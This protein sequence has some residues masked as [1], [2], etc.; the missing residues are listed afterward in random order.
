MKDLVRH[1]ADWRR[2]CP[3][4]DD[5]KKQCDSIKKKL[6]LLHEYQQGNI[7]PVVKE[8]QKIVMQ[9]SQSSSEE[10]EEVKE[11]R[12]RKIR[13]KNYLTSNANPAVNTDVGSLIFREKPPLKKNN[14]QERLPQRLLKIHK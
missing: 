12:K 1:A 3:V 6:I 14:S 8:A 4:P 10:E 5:V 7:R 13:I 11:K 2:P 9:N